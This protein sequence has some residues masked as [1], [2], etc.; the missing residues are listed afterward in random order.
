MVYMGRRIIYMTVH[1]S[2]DGGTLKVEDP[3]AFTTDI[4]TVRPHR[5]LPYM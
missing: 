5:A 4:H 3:P 2:N 1:G